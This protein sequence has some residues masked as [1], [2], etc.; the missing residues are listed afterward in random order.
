MIEDEGDVFDLD[1]DKLLSTDLFTRA[2]EE[3]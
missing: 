1:R 2:A 3:G